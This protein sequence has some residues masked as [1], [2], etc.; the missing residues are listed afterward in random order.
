MDAQVESSR[1]DWLWQMVRA[2]GATGRFRVPVLHALYDLSD[3]RSANQLCEL[4]RRYAEAGDE[5]FRTRLY[6]IV[7]QK[8]VADSPWPGEEEIV[9]LDGERAFLFAAR[10]RGRR[11]ADREWEWDDGSL[12]ALAVERFGEGHVSRLVEASTDEAVRRFREHWRQYQ[13]KQAEQQIHR[14]HQERMVAT[15]LQEVLR[16]AEDD[17]SCFWFRGWGIHADEADLRAVLPRIRAEQAPTVIAK[18][19]RVFSARPLP[20]FDTRFIELCRHADDE[21]RRR[22]FAALEPNAHPLVREFALTEFEKGVRNGSVVALFINNYRHGD[23]RR[24]LEA[25]ELPDDECERHWLL[26]AVIKVLEKNPEADC[27]RLG[28]IGYALTRCENCRF[29]AVRLL[30]SRH[31]APGWVTVECRYDSG[32]DCRE[33]VGKPTE[34]TEASSASP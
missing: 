1:A 11:L 25:M 31:A 32:E 28:V 23:E 7:E 24:I 16:A 14:S 29:H 20:D 22:A 19:L 2:V 9:A 6:E 26:M 5:S 18:L 8:P 21:V 3:D 4:A 12:T 27:S 13:Q 33:L 10:V 30:L 15:S 17:G 34:A